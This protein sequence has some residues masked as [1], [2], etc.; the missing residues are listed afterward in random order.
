M[1]NHLKFCSCQQ[2]RRGKRSKNGSDTVRAVVRHTRRQ[3]KQDLKQGK[4]PAKAVSAGY[5]D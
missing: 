1:P 5:T 4:E 3:V 2:C